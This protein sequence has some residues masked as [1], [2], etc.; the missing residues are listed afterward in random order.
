VLRQGYVLD[1]DS[2]ASYE[3]ELGSSP[4]RSGVSTVESDLNLLRHARESTGILRAARIVY[5]SRDIPLLI[6]AWTDLPSVTVEERPAVSAGDESTALVFRFPALGT[7][8]RA[9]VVHVRVGRVLGTLRVIGSTSLRFA[10]VRPLAEILAK[11]IR[12]AL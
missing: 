3:R 12:G 11:R 7:E 4:T 6:A 5:S 9:A 1:R 8:L 10:D 2:L